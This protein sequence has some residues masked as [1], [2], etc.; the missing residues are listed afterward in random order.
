MDRETLAARGRALRTKEDLLDLLNAVKRDEMAACGLAGRYHPFEMRLLNYC[1]NPNNDRRRYR[2]FEIAKK[3]GG[4]RQIAAPGSRAYLSLLRCVNVLFK[5]LYAP[6][7]HA[8]G[9]AEGRSVADNAAAHC[10]QNYVYN[11]DLK[12]FFPSIAQARVWKRL[13]LPPLS[14]RQP[15]A[16]VLAGLCAIKE[17]SGAEASYVL[18]QGAPTSPIVTNMVC[19]RLDRRLAGLARRFGVRFTRYADDITFSSMH[20]VYHRD[21]E[22][23]R[24][25]RRIVE[26]QGFALNEGKTRLQKRGGRQEVTGLVVNE[27]PNVPRRYLREVRGLLHIWERH[28]YGEATKRLYPR[29]RREKGHTKRGVPALENL[30]EGKLM[31]LKMVRGGDDGAYRALAARFAALAAELRDGG[32][33]L[34]SMSTE[35]VADF[36]RRQGTE[37]S[38]VVR[39]AGDGGSPAR[40][41]ARFALEGAAETA[42]VARRL[43][44]EALGRKEELLISLCRR[45]GGKPFWLVHG[46]DWSFRGPEAAVDVDALN[47][48]LDELLK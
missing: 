43:P 9:F 29:Y 38:F 20:N 45:G 24:E 17:G 10:G 36:E 15:V 2:R 40:R 1:C 47:A 37:V 21:G 16:N 19:D 39:E 11:V 42:S 48:E 22:F 31:Y 34:R 26:G 32:E 33:G 3:S 25:L 44:P 5:A 13:Q 6:S 4:R 27:R 28:G 23:C 30:L 41:H 46:A 12:D 18:P 8:M 14:L 35:T 7:E